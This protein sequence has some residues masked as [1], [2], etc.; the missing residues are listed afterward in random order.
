[1][2]PGKPFAEFGSSVCVCSDFPDPSVLFSDHG[3][4]AVRQ[5]CAVHCLARLI[6]GRLWNMRV[7]NFLS[8]FTERCGQ[9]A[10]PCTSWSLGAA[11]HQKAPRCPKIFEAHRC[12]MLRLVALHL[13]QV[14]SSGC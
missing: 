3:I 13:W 6:F 9:E 8:A 7:F 4:S 10:Y 11:W 5:A 2:L 14:D 12:D 1:M